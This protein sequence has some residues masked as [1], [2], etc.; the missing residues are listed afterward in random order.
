MDSYR[1]VY[2]NNLTGIINERGEIVG[3]AL[4][5]ALPDVI[6]G[7]L[8][9]SVPYS[10]QSVTIILNRTSLTGNVVYFTIGSRRI[11]DMNRVSYFTKSF[12]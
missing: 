7:S 1:L 11:S 6:E 8:I 2:S 4:S 12:T 10:R 5:V 3:N 9:P